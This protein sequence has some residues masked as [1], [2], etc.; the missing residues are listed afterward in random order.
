MSIIRIRKSFLKFP[1]GITVS[2]P[3]EM[4]TSA[5]IWEDKIRNLFNRR[6]INKV[7]KSEY[8]AKDK[9]QLKCWKDKNKVKNHHWKLTN[10]VDISE[11]MS[12][13]TR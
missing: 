6:K 1:K 2:C 8:N 13:L 3:S 5:D 11:K 9:G 12:V 10:T 7:E 4:R